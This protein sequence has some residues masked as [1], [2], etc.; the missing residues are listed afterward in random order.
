MADPYGDT[1]GTWTY[2]LT[3]TATPITQVPPTTGTVPT[4]T[5]ATF[6]DQLAVS[7]SPGTA[8]FTTTT[9][10]AALDVSPTG[11]V[12]TTGPLAAGSYA[13][14]GTVADPYG[15]TP[16]TWTYTLTVTAVTLVQQPPLTGSTTT[17]PSSGF[18][19][20]LAV[21]GGIGPVTF[22]T[23]TATPEV[24]ISGTGQVTTL[25]P[26]A[27]G[28][29]TTSGTVADAYGDTG[30]WSYDLTVTPVTIV[31]GPPTSGTVVSTTLSGF[32]A[33]LT[34]TAPGTVTFAATGGTTA[35]FSVSGSGL[36]VPVGALLP[37]DHT[38]TGTTGDQFGDTGTWTYTLHVLH[39]APTVTVVSPSA[40]KTAGGTRI[41]LT[42]TNFVAGATVSFGGS[43]GT[44]V[45]VT[46][47]T[48]I[49]VTAPAHAAGTVTVKV[50]TV[51]GT[52]GAGS[53]YTY[54]AA[55][56]LSGLSPT[57]GPTAGG[58]TVTLTGTNFASGATV[59][60]GGSA[61]T[62][63][64]VTGPTTIKAK[65][66]A[67]AAGNVTVTVT[68]PGGTSGGRTFTYYSPPTLTS[69]TPTGGPAAGGTTVTLRGSNFVS[70]STTV[71][72]GGTPIGAGSV[73][74][75]SSS[76]IHVA[77]PA[78]AAGSVSVTVSTPGGRPAP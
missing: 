63:V 16:G 56:T 78:H 55:P 50:T 1:P 52:S 71:T 70:G 59:S 35:A 14:S 34:A 17:A 9:G 20:Q 25:G 77:A 40:G 29:Y 11:Q 57:A 7:G 12:T 5:S 2:T 42:G 66:P 39:P 54:D 64:T 58:T 19:H 76:H 15:D 41:T 60:F 22:A 46:S 31:Q 10:T 32:S 72:F 73:T 8:T 6:T 38:V 3:V 26:L 24:T 67:H 28:L 61:G 75:V 43:A 23:T 48:T 45:T 13:V 18:T 27:A 37:G 47:S 69:I 30:T 4:T 53:T 51:G 74:Y 44:S 36:L 21:S 33:Q 62:T 65:A 68:T 49:K